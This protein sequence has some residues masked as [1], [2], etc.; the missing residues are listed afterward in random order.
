L[1]A[2]EISLETFDVLHVVF[3]PQSVDGRSIQVSWFG[4]LNWEF[5][6]W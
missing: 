6:C 5:I 3:G 4:S 2:I 1:F